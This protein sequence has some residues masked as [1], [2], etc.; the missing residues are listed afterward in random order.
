V[1]FVFFNFNELGTLVGKKDG[2]TVV[3][4]S[5][6]AFARSFPARLCSI[7]GSIQLS[8]NTIRSD[9]MVNTITSLGFTCKVFLYRAATSFVT[10]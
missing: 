5:V 7:C 8:V 2:V 1:G 10:L 3:C 9:T 4:K 6:E